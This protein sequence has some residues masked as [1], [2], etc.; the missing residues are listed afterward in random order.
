MYFDDALYSFQGSGN[1]IHA[2]AA[3][4]DLGNLVSSAEARLKNQLIGSCFCKF[5]GLVCRNDALFDCTTN[6]LLLG[7]AS[8]IIRNFDYNLV[9]L[10]IGVQFHGSTGWLSRGLALLGRLDA[11]V[12][13][14]AYQVRQR[15]SQSIQDAFVEIRIFSDD[16]QL[17]IAS[18]M[19]CD[20]AHKT[21]E[22]PEELL[23]RHHADLHHGAL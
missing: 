4:R 19:L 1:R 3:P 8:P 10:V 17:H 20:V 9:S 22:A 12:N 15:L 11:M 2:H 6:Q 13:G 21:R 7:N 16:F 5:F 18:A 14:I 23:D